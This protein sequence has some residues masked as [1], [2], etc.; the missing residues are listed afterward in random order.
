MPLTACR[1]HC[2]ICREE[3]RMMHRM[4]L[5]AAPFSMIRSGQKTIELRLNDEKRRQVKVGDF[6]EFTSTEQPEEKMQVRVTA[7]HRFRSFA[8]LYE[9]LPLLQCGYTEEELA[10]ADPADME[11][12]YSGEEQEKYGVL[13]IEV[14]LTAL[15]KF[16]DAQENGYNSWCSDYA[17]ALEEIRSGEKRTHWMWYIFPQ[18]KGLGRSGTTAYFSINSLE[19]AR[20]YCQHPVLGARLR[21]ISGVLLTLRTSDPMSV[22]GSPDAF[23]LRS[24]MTLFAEAAPDEPVF[25]QVLDKFC[26]SRRDE[27][28]LRLLGL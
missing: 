28:T 27:K 3:Y 21:E 1:G 11:A 5:N 14:R 16:L 2:A 8:E 9:H 23:K 25:G 18:I 22:F 13:G 24:C 12:Y 10:H 7:L 19:E 6:I 17:A 4:K 26:M 15:Q 20:D